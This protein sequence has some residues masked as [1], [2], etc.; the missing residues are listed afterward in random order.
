MRRD[1]DKLIN[2]LNTNRPLLKKYVAQKMTKYYR[3]A[4]RDGNSA[5]CFVVMDDC[6]T[7]NLG[8]MKKGD[9]MCPSTWSAPAKHARG[10]LYKPEEWNSIFEEYGIKMLRN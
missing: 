1:I 2:F 4:C 10:S 8:K 6:E 3:I 9:I 5:Y 7:R